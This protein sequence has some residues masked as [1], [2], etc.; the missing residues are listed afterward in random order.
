MHL[1]LAPTEL[2]LE[3]PRKDVLI[4][5]NNHN[6]TTFTPNLNE[7]NKNSNEVNKVVN[8]ISEVVVSDQ[9]VFQKDFE[10]HKS[11]SSIKVHLEKL[12]DDIF[13][14][15]D[16]ENIEIIKEI[17]DKKEVRFKYDTRDNTLSKQQNDE[18][19]NVDK[20]VQE[21][22]HNLECSSFTPNERDEIE[23][24]D[25]SEDSDNTKKT[26][27]YIKDAENNIIEQKNLS[28][29]NADKES[30]VIENNQ[31]IQE[32]F[33]ESGEIENNST[34][35]NAILEKDLSSLNCTENPEEIDTRESTV[36]T[37]KR[38]TSKLE[39][40]NSSDRHEL[41][42]QVIESVDPTESDDNN[43]EILS[44][45]ESE[46]SKTI[47]ESISE[48]TIATTIHESDSTNG[49]VYKL[50]VDDLEFDRLQNSLSLEQINSGKDNSWFESSDEFQDPFKRYNILRMNLRNKIMNFK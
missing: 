4:E 30:D 18:S 48:D 10:K 49:E 9:F 41:A 20:S 33:L 44:A 11:D 8:C 14:F 26:P 31:K 6:S 15:Y 40:L 28:H 24:S 7:G 42:Q 25:D 27:Q 34:T 16:D 37:V 1:E 23:N 22:E 5:H 21:S 50:E 39:N 19:E 3:I 2:E 47:V 38:S 13:E 35:N 12:F 43:K 46:H 29:L 17:K 36:E 32:Y 45:S